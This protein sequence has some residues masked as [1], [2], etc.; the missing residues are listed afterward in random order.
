MAVLGDAM[1]LLDRILG[2]RRKDTAPPPLARP[3]ANAA[4]DPTP[5]LSVQLLGGDEDLEVV[6]ESHYQPTLWSTCGRAPGQRVRHDIV[7]V[8][9]PE[10]TNPY[11]ENAIRVVIDGHTAGYLARFEAAEYLPGLHRLMAT[12]GAHIALAGVIV[13]GGIRQDGPGFL[14]V[15]LEHD[16]I[17]FGLAS[18]RAPTARPRR[19]GPSAMRTGFSEAWLSDLQDD[20]YDLSWYS[21]LPEQDAAAIGVLN[22]LIAVDPD[23]I[24]RHFQFAELERRLYRRRD[25]DGTALTQFD[26][27]CCRHDAEMDVMRSAL[28]AKFGRVPF[29]ETYKQMAIRQQKA[30]NWAACKQWAERGIKLYGN[31][32][33]DASWVDDLLKRLARAVTK[34]APAKRTLDAAIP[35]RVTVPVA[36]AETVP[37]MLEAAS[38]EVLMCER[39]RQQFERLRLRGRKPST[40]PSCRR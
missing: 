27:A 30:K 13:G 31:D 37:P 2:R 12:H 28:H 18:S 16:R 7:A 19:N 38:I 40:C 11:D 39:C 6:G 10:P 1:R 26:H 29:L 14:G 23:P 25:I 4:V 5:R 36:P 35:G 32:A 15:W 24:D 22:G 17:E 34:L 3:F 33:A 21:E 9:V 8:L 20:S